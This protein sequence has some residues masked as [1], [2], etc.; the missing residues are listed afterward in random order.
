M[1]D[2][3]HL[4]SDA[5]DW[6]SLQPPLDEIRQHYCDAFR[7]GNAGERAAQEIENVLQQPVRLTMNGLLRSLQNKLFA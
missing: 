5:F 7:D 1:G 4:L 6:A 2:L 3:R